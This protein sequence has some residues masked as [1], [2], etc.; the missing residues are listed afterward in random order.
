MKRELWIDG[1]NVI[2]QLPDL[3]DLLAS[4]PQEA[5]RRFLRMLASPASRSSERWFVIFD[6]P[7]PGRDFAPGPI[8]IVYAP[9]ADAWIVEELRDHPNARLITVVSSDVKDIGRSAR[10]LGAIVIS[11]QDFIGRLR[12]RRKPGPGAPESAGS[13]KPEFSSEA[14]V[15]YWLERFGERPAADSG[16]D[17]RDL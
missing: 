6:G 14:E 5:R 10:Q 8:E 12:R 7:R 13:E 17:E 2:H 9:S 4:E 11:A 1:F 15:N 3:V 16:E